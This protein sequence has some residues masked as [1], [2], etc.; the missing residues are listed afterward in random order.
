MNYL[1]IEEIRAKFAEHLI[2]YIGYSA[3]AAQAAVADFPDPEENAYLYEEFI[4]FCEIDDEEFEKCACC[5]LLSRIGI[6]GVPM[7]RFY[8]Y[9]LNRIP[10]SNA[11]DEYIKSRRLFQTENLDNSHFPSDENELISNCDIF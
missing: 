4:E 2:T 10:S 7:F 11:E 6:N 8:T 5:T 3:D 9:N 1:S